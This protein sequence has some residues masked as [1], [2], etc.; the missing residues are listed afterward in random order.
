[1]PSGGGFGIAAPAITAAGT[2]FS[3]QSSRVRCA[4]NS[5]MT[6]STARCVPG[7]RLTAS[8]GH[9]FRAVFQVVLPVISRVSNDE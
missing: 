6:T 8:H 1:M 3:I 7:G 2:S 5:E 9:P 4:A